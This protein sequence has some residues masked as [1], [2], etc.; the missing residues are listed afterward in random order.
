MEQ[1]VSYV[2][3]MHLCVYTVKSTY[4]LHADS[5]HPPSKFD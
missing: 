3:H 4:F 1:M 2:R 5:L